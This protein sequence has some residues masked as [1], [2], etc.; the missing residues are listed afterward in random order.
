MTKNTKV[1]HV[2]DQ[3][4]MI[5]SSYSEKKR[6]KIDF[7]KGRTEELFTVLSNTNPKIKVGRSALL[8]ILFTII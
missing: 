6:R 2:S 3:R 7:V 8:F 5:S 1:V 4:F